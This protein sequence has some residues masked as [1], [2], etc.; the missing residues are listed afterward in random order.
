MSVLLWI[1]DSNIVAVFLTALKSIQSLVKGKYNHWCDNG[2][3]ILY[4][5]MLSEQVERATEDEK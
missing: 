3:L 4:S 2:N 1:Y 5:F